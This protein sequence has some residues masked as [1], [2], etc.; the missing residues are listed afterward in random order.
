MG[1]GGECK[2]L[3]AHHDEGSKHM[4][5]VPLTGLNQVEIGSIILLIHQELVH[6]N[7]ASSDS[8]HGQPCLPGLLLIA[9]IQL[10]EQL[11]C[12][13]LHSAQ[14]SEEEACRL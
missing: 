11:L 13:A 9:H 14:C 12:K 4:G 10:R 1:S 5:D 6:T 7:D 3:G 8:D 2:G